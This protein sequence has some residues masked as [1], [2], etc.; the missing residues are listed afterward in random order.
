M[1]SPYI[2]R[3]LEVWKGPERSW[4]VHPSHE[5]NFATVL[6]CTR[7][8]KSRRRPAFTQILNL[9]I[10]ASATIWLTL[11]MRSSTR[12]LL[13]VTASTKKTIL[14]ESCESRRLIW[15]SRPAAGTSST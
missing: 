1:I 5:A 12:L 2:G 10:F 15:I 3:T 11:S 13:L 9:V 4:T 14:S 8:S 7:F 6:T